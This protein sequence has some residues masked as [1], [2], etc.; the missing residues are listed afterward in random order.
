MLER[1]RRAT[2]AVG[3][4][5]SVIAGQDEVTPALRSRRWAA[6]GAS[7]PKRRMSMMPSQKFGSD[8]PSTASTVPA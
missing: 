4:A 2:S 7:T 5:A 3:N 8:W 6:S 1:V